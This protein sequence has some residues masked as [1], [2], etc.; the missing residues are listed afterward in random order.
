MFIKNY[1]IFA[2]ARVS[3]TV[4]QACAEDQASNND[5]MAPRPT[6]AALTFLSIRLVQAA[7]IAAQCAASTFVNEL[8]MSFSDWPS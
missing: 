5:P 6:K 1:N 2:Y 4:R 3:A 7:C 8:Q